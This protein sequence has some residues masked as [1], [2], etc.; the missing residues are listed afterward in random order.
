MRKKSAFPIALDRQRTNAAQGRCPGVRN[1]TCLAQQTAFTPFE[2]AASTSSANICPSKI[3]APRHQMHCQ[4]KSGHLPAETAVL[5]STAVATQARSPRAPASHGAGR[6][7][8]CTR[9][10]AKTRLRRNPRRPPTGLA[11]PTSTDAAR[12]PTPTSIRTT[13]TTAPA[14]AGEPRP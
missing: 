13:D 3:Y 12:P 1:R 2:A 14:A 7:V 10:V 5:A 6:R 9:S 4:D 11:E 8:D